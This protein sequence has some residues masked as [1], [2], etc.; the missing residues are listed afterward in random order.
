MLAGLEKAAKVVGIKQTKKAIRESRAVKVYL[1]ADAEE[2]VL[3]PIHELCR[4][5]SVTVDM[6][7]SM[8][9]LG[10]A[11]GIEVGAAAVALIRE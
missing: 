2:R 5:G 7:E 1:A 6:V 11:C 3:R 9:E 4:E 8:N 10:A